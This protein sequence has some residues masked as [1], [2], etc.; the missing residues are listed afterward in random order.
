MPKMKKPLISDSYDKYLF[1]VLIF[2]VVMVAV[3]YFV[4]NAQIL[5]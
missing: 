3:V 5:A 4:T 2:V 1:G